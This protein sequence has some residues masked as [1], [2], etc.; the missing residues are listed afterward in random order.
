MDNSSS[1]FH[2]SSF[3]PDYHVD[4]VDEEV[5]SSFLDVLHVLLSSLQL[6]F[7][8]TVM[9]CPSKFVHSLVLFIMK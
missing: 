2:V 4:G 8:R 5:S 6:F 3:C 9:S 1:F 7:I